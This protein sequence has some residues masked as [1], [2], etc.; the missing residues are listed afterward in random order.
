VIGYVGMTGLATGPHLHFEF[1]IDDVHVDPLQ[2]AMPEV[3]A[4]TTEHHAAFDAVARPLALRLGLLRG[5]KL[6]Q[7]E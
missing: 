7:A 3:P 6:A 1:K 2:I 5:T 4:I